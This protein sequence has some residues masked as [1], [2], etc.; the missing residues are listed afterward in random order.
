MQLIFTQK[1]PFYN[2]KKT[3]YV[4]FVIVTNVNYNKSFSS[5]IDLKTSFISRL[6]NKKFM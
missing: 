6:M 4:D 5:N 2:F 3:N 1:N